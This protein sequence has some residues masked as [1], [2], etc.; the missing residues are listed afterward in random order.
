MDAIHPFAVVALLEDWP[1]RGLC[2]GQSGMVVE[3][4][5]PGV[6]EV[7]FDDNEGRAYASLALRAD[8]L[9]VPHREWVSA[10]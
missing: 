2:R 5:A 6:F 8:Q 4:L 9:R 7:E 10:G 1:S 3:Q